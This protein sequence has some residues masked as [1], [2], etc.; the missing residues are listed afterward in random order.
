MLEKQAYA[1][2]KTLKDFRVYILHSHVI[3]YVPIVVIKDILTHEDPDGKIAKWIIVLL[4][5]DL[6]INPTKLVRWQGLANMM[7][8]SNCDVLGVNLLDCGPSASNQ[9]EQVTIYLDFLALPW[10][11]VIIYVL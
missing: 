4:E 6:E 2:V 1:L 3:T 5:Y 7:T 11:K 8:Q 9:N 10:Y